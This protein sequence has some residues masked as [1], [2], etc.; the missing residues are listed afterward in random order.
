MCGQRSGTQ[1]QNARVCFSCHTKGVL[2]LCSIKQASAALSL[3][4]RL[5]ALGIDELPPS[6]SSLQEF[7]RN[8]D[9]SIN[10]LTR[11]PAGLEV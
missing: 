1:D 9:L 6:F 2:C 5:S 11:M 10:F 3:D 7:V 4:V 8:V